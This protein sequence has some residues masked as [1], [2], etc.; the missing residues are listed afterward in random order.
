MLVKDVIDVDYVN[1]KKPSM[2][3]AMPKCSFKCDKLN[4]K[5]VCQNSM[6][7]EQRDIDVDFKTLITRY[8]NSSAQAICFQGLEPF[9]SYN[10]LLC[11]IKDFR[12]NSMDDIV[13]YTGYD[14]NEI[15]NMVRYI[16]AYGIRN[17]IIKFGRFI[18]G[19]QPH[20]DEILGVNLASDNQYA[21]RIC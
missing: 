16:A 19:H 4:G 1:Y 2:I 18:Q 5:K 7:A 10:E 17:V 9:D 13:I 15:E 12:A 3:I 6:L 11:F 21:E 14:R 20:Y 8:L